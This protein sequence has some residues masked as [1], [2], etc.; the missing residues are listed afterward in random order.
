MQPSGTFAENLLALT[1]RRLS[2]SALSER[3][4]SLG[5]QPWSDLLAALLRPLAQQRMHPD[6]FY[7]GMRLV[8]IDGTTFN[9]ANTPTVK[10]TVV[11]TKARRGTEAFLRLR[12]VVLSELGIHNPL[13]AR[14]GC[15]NESETA[16][17]TTLVTALKK[18]DL[19]IGDRNYG[20]L[21]W[22]DRL[23]SLRQQ[24]HFLFR[25]KANSRVR[26]VRR[27][28]DGSR[29]VSVQDKDTGRAFLLREIKAS[30]RRP[31]QKWTRVRFWTD[32]LDHTRYPAEEMILLY[33]R[34]WEQ[35][36]AFRELKEHISDDN[37]LL[38]H[39]MVTATQEIH[40]MIMAQAYVARVRAGA[41]RNQKQPVLQISFKKTLDACRNLGWLWAI[42]GA[43]LTSTQRQDI[44][45]RVELHL[46]AQA[47]RKRRQRSC[48]RL[49]RQPI[50]RWQ[51]L[52]RNTY[53]HGK[54]EY[55][56]N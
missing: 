29:I 48:P 9:I 52:T 1:G 38:S 5:V 16:L 15:K 31:H 20:Y 37:L 42:A 14:M 50:H 2:E 3:R 36:L 55:H 35:E 6:A 7:K 12:C 28:P 41:A 47:S 44:L 46:A 17:A 51:R 30:V 33:A 13:A 18:G 53:A 45:H 26:R 24:P 32:L 27:L 39:T 11:K 8:G 21:P 22:V 56:V 10:R 40:A 23:Q 34:R 43:I 4:Q 19:L 54:I 49:V 25:V